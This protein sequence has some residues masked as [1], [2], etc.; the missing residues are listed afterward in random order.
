MSGQAIQ[1]FGNLR[2]GTDAQ[3][4][5]DNR[6]RSYQPTKEG[7]KRM[8]TFSTAGQPEQIKSI[9]DCVKHLQNT[10]IRNSGAISRSLEGQA[11]AIISNWFRENLS[12][13]NVI[14]PGVAQMAKWGRCSDRQA[15]RNVKQLVQWGVLQPVADLQGGRTIRTAYTV[16]PDMLVRAL[17]A[18]CVSISKTLI[19]K[20]RSLSDAICGAV[21]GDKK[22]DSVSPPYKDDL[23][24]EVSASVDAPVSDNPPLGKIRSRL[25][26]GIWSRYQRPRNLKRLDIPAQ[27][28]NLGSTAFKSLSLSGRAQA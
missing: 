13:N 17:M 6:A 7:K 2:S 11:L 26:A 18:A 8:C 23:N 19:E 20:I 28:M 22:G 16:H 10:I 25:M 15:Q 5:A 9:N 24:V 27:G 3:V 4:L 14:R 1:N 12:G 21:K